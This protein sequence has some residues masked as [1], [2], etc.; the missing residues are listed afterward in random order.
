MY[1]YDAN[2]AGLRNMPTASAMQQHPQLGS[3][4]GKTFQIMIIKGLQLLSREA[5][6][7]ENTQNSIGM[8]NPG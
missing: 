8:G 4:A 5:T 1:K 6:G 3:I 2:T 7:A